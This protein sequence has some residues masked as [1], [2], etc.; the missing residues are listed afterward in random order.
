MTFTTTH[1]AEVKDEAEDNGEF[2]NASV[3][4]DVATLQPTYKLVWGALGESNALAVAQTLGFDRRVVA[5]GREWKAKLS[6][7]RAA[8]MDAERL[9]DSLQ[10]RAA[11]G[12]VHWAARAASGC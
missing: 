4:F 8:Q 9:R 11:D 2:V 5:A 6:E 3:Q 7:L 12:F 1:H 10:V